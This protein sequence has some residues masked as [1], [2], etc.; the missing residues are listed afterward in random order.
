MALKVLLLVG[1]SVLS[2]PLG[3]GE[4][5][6]IES[7][8]DVFLLEDC[9]RQNQYY[10]GYRLCYQHK[11]KLNKKTFFSHSLAHSRTDSRYYKYKT[12]EHFNRLS[13]TS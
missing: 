4:C 6:E 11:R 12:E 9:K 3:E 2:V 13:S 8:N 1:K 7:L 5:R 10:L